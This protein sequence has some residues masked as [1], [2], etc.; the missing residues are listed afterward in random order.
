MINS[1]HGFVILNAK[2][3]RSQIMIRVEHIEY[4]HVIRLRFTFMSL[5]HASA[6]RK[7]MKRGVIFQ[8]IK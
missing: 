6:V 7:L 3:E 1:R 4:S 8:L 5:K 2:S